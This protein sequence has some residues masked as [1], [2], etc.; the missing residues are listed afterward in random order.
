MLL[1]T[2]KVFKDFPHHVFLSFMIGSAL[3]PSVILK[4]VYTAQPTSTVGPSVGVSTQ[5][6]PVDVYQYK[7]SPLAFPTAPNPYTV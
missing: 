6:S 3:L 7:H 2:Y 1:K 5:T 4:G